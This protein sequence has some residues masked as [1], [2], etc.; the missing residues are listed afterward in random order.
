MI[1]EALKHP[2]VT[3]ITYAELDPLLLALFEKFPTP[4]TAAE[5]NDRRVSITNT[6]GR[7]LLKTTDD[8]YDVIFL[9]ILDPSNLQTNR[10]F[11]QEFFR[12][13]RNMLKPGGI[14]VIG[15]PGSLTYHSD[16]M[17][18]LNSCIYH[19]LETVFSHIRVIPGD[20]SH[21]LLSSDAPGVSTADRVGIVRR[22]MR[23]GI[24]AQAVMPWRIENKLHRGWQQWY[25]DFLEGGSEKINR[26]FQ[27]VGLFYSLSHWNERFAPTF[28]GI[29]AQLERIDLQVIA[30]ALGLALLLYVVFGGKGAGT[31]RSGIT[32]A[33][34]TTGFA[35]MYFDLMIIFAFQSI[36]GYVFSWI[37]LLVATFMA[38]AAVGALLTTRA[39]FR[40]SGCLKA[41]VGIDAAIAC[42]AVGCPCILITAHGAIGGLG[43]D[44][45]ART[46]FLLISFI[47][48]TL[49]GAQFPLANR[50]YPKNGTDFTRTAGLLY[51]SDL[52]GGW[53]GGIVGAVVLLP[54]L[55][56]ASTGAAIGMVKVA[57]LIVLTVQIQRTLGGGNHGRLLS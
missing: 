22:M 2:T 40:P 29:F 56:I 48:G 38:G 37:G 19:T 25:A 49:T 4:L 42:F 30:G 21:L 44:P 51:A 5:L 43:A 15:L 55:G 10:F 11:T 57:G 45:F 52:L 33:I 3:A 32:L 1:N 14:L 8:T 53:F 47:C 27:P 12:L 6:D 28:S 9:G 16:A 13:A 18:D 26:D 41:F 39:D 34:F 31:R 20:G 46:L 35:G 36:Y 23:R 7:R 24:S 54:I 50:I 17:R